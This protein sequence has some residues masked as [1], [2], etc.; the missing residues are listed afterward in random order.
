MGAGLY[1]AGNDMN[2]LSAV[3]VDCTLGLFDVS[4]RGGPG[5]VS[6]GLCCCAEFV[7]CRGP[8]AAFGSW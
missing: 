4:L 6:I 8:G 1:E 5:V 2:A 7:A 3:G